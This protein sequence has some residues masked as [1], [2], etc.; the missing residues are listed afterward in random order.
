M[1]KLKYGSDLQSILQITCANTDCMPLFNCSKEKV[2]F[3]SANHCFAASQEKSTGGK[4]Q[5]KQTAKALNTEVTKF[6]PRACLGQSWSQRR[7][8]LSQETRAVRPQTIDQ[9]GPFILSHSQKCL[10]GRRCLSSIASPMQNIFGKRG[11]CQL[12]N[13]DS[14]QIFHFETSV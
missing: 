10:R 3:L 1:N 12:L 6:S 5:L 4:D 2:G 7:K 13:A 14:I 9:N 11:S 8:F